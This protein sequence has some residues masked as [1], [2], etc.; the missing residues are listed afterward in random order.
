MGPV[1]ESCEDVGCRLEER[2]AEFGGVESGELVMVGEAVCLGEG[3]EIGGGVV[4]NEKVGLIRMGED[5]AALIWKRERPD[6][7]E[8]YFGKEDLGSRA[9]FWTARLGSWVSD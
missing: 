3:P 5:E 2:E 6:W 7:E 4:K 1:L 8:T 9:D